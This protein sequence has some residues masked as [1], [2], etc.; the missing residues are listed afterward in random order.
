MKT[1]FEKFRKWRHYQEASAIVLVALAAAD[2]IWSAFFGFGQI[3][4]RN[5]C[6]AAFIA[7]I[8]G[9]KTISYSHCPHCGKSV[10][11]KWLGRDAMGRNCARRIANCQPIQC[12]HCGKEIDT[13]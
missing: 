1:D 11:S 4:N 12:F 9:F 3:N 13:V 5:V 10:M 7:S 8:M 2:I 6:I